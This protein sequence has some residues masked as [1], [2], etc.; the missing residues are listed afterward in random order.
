MAA[1]GAIEEDL[2]KE[3]DNDS[4]K[5]DVYDEHVEKLQAAISKSIQFLPYQ[6]LKRLA[7]S[8]LKHGVPLPPS[9]PP[10]A[11][12]WSKAFKT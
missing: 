9:S 6:E 12:S 1:N 4:P 5:E 10:I 11:T 3:I 7:Y 2:Q 8:W